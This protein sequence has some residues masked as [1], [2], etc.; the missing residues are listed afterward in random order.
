[1]TQCFVMSIERLNI[2]VCFVLSLATTVEL[3]ISVIFPL[4]LK[5]GLK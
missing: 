5:K 4:N 1:M 3:K 2:D